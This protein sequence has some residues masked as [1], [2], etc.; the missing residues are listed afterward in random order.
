VA[1]TLTSHEDSLVLFDAPKFTSKQEAC[2][3][4]SYPQ[5]Y[6]F[7]KQK[8]HYMIGMSVP[9][10]MTAQIALKVYEQWLKNL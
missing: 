10:V 8:P 5:D 7:C 2:S 3:I 1:T 4:G 9:P 6:D